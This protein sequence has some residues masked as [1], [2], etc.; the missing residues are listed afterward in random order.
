M[1]RLFPFF[2]G[3]F[4]GAG[5]LLLRLTLAAG[6]F[7]EATAEFHES[8]ISPVFP[9]V[10]D[11]LPAALLLAGLWTPIA[12]I[13]VCAFQLGMLALVSGTTE[14]HLLRASVGLCLAVL[15]PGA[16]SVDARVFGPRRVEIKNLRND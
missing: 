16:L 13:L 6:L 4:P 14:L 1:R 15:G 2:P 10:G 12:G 11:I 9:A 8:D 5:L 3:G 7:M